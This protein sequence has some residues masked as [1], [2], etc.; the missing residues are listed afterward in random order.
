MF[1]GTANAQSKK[2]AKVKPSANAQT[3]KVNEP[4]NQDTIL[5][6]TNNFVPTY[7]SIQDTLVV[8]YILSGYSL[9]NKLYLTTSNE[10]DTLDFEMKHTI[11]ERVSN[12]FEG[13][14]IMLFTGGQKRELW[15]EN[16]GN[17]ILLEQWNNDSLQLANYLPLELKKY[18]SM[19]LF[20]YIGGSFGGGDRYSSGT[21]NLRVGTYL[22]KD[23]V[24]ASAT[25]N[26][27]YNTTNYNSQFAG[28]LGIDART[29]PSFLRVDKMRLSPYVGTGISWILSPDS[30]FEWRLLFGGCWFLGPGSLDFGLQYGTKTG[31]TFTVGY[32]FR[33]GMSSSNKKK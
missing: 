16:D 22:Y 32:T 11:L 28:D 21:L 29:Y 18:G 15:V 13:Y 23:I 24:D 30:S 26:L 19:K 4:I 20:Y 17:L 5:D 14:D 10:Y 9:D 12:S 3:E 8:K 1:C 33:P 31:S 25:M 6:T 7:K 2:R 27:G